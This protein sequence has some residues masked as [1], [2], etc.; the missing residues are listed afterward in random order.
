MK[1]ASRSNEFRALPQ[2]GCSLCHPLSFQS[3]Q[4][5][6]NGLRRIL[7][8]FAL[9]LCGGADDMRCQVELIRHEVVGMQSFDAILGESVGREIGQIES[10]DDI[11]PGPDRGRE[12]VAIIRIRQLQSRDEVFVAGDK[13]V[14]DMG[15]HQVAGPLQLFALQVWTIF[16][17]APHPLVVDCVSPL[18]AKKVRKREMHQQVA[19]RCRVE[20]ASVIK[21]REGAHVQ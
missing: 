7:E 1:K 8:T 4:V 10:H 3:L 6:G 17:D 5:L 2:G 21:C 20:H 16:E 9:S 14:A 15:I 19:K 11:G 12:D 18:G 13:A